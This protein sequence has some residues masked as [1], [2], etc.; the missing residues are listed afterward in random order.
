MGVTI[1]P[2]QREVIAH[3]CGPLTSVFAGGAVRSGKS[4]SVMVSFALWLMAK[5]SRYDAAIV[6]Q[7]IETIMRNLGFDLMDTARTMGMSIDMDRAYG[8]RMVV[9]T[10]KQQTSIWLVGANDAKARKRI[11]GSTLQG[12]VVEELPLLPFD[13]FQMAWSRLSVEGAKM[14]ASYNPEGPAH[15]A[16]RQVL[17]NVGSYD[18]VDLK[19]QLRDNPTLPESVIERYEDSYHGHWYKRLIKGEWSAASGAIFPEWKFGPE[20]APKTWRRHIALDWAVSGTLAVLHIATRGKRGLVLNEMYH[21]AREEQVLT[22]EQV[23]RRVLAWWGKEFHTRYNVQVWLDPNT[24]ASFKR[25]LRKHGF[26]VRAADNTVL[27]GLRVTADRLASGDVTISPKCRNLRE[28]LSGYVWDEVAAD[29]GIDAPLKARDH[30]C[31]AL[32][33]WAYSTGKAYANIRPTEVKEALR[34]HPISF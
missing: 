12:L 20:V 2:R 15:W 10:K 22:E 1:S 25:L 5:V 28:E 13:F 23:L 21:N 17:D 18:G 14:W 33:Y 3:A 9:A 6:G 19:F 24:P 4:Y 27:P 31:D 16:K 30:G 29:K 8:T 26:N 7:S 11:Q 32:R 34:A